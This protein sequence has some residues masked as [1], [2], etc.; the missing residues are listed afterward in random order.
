MTCL[1]W[2]NLS[3]QVSLGTMVHSCS[4]LSRG[5][6]LVT[7]LQVIKM[8]MMM[9]M[10]MMMAMMMMVAMMMMMAM[11]MP[12]AMMMMKMTLLSRGTTLVTN[13]MMVMMMM[14]MTVAMTT[15]IVLADVPAGLLWVEVADLLWHVYHGGGGLVVALLRPLLEGA[16]GSADLDGQLLAAGVAHELAGLFL[17]VLGGA[18]GLVDG[19]ADLLPL[20]VTDLLQGLVALLGGLVEGLLLEGDLAGLLEVLLADLLLTGLELGDVGV[21]AL[22]RVLVGALQD[23]LLLQ[24]GHRLLLLHAA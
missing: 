21:V 3:T 11:M 2:L 19:L 20:P 4:G 10:V 13:L 12:M 23:G 14:I 15:T 16:A 5:T 9:L 8:M 6:S 7:N 18:G 24:G 22:L 1:G 17:D